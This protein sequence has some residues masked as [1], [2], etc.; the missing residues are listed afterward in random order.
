MQEVEH[1]IKIRGKGIIGITNAPGDGDLSGIVQTITENPEMSVNGLCS[2]LEKKY[3]CYA[4]P[5]I[6][7][8]II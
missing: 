2:L 6:F 7:E 4:I 8:V 5:V 1:Y 3:D